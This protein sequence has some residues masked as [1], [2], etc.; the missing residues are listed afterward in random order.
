MVDIVQ[1]KLGLFQYEKYHSD[2][3]HHIQDPE[4]SFGFTCLVTFGELQL[5]MLAQDH[6]HNIT[7][8]N[9]KD[10]PIGQQRDVS[11]VK[12]NPCVFIEL[13]PIL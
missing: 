5:Q 13:A 6:A 8:V 1:Y 10:H 7:K 3:T 12:V 9:D 4:F 11:H 2:R